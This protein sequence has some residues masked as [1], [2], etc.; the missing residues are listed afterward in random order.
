MIDSMAYTKKIEIQYYTETQD[1]I[2]N[3]EQTWTTLYTPWAKIEE[4]A[5]GKEYYE[6]AQTNSENDV[7]FKLRYSSVLEGKLTSELRV[8]Y[9]NAYYDVKHM[10]GIEEHSLEV[11]IRTVKINGGVR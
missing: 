1:T 4:N 6:A 5:T 7:V 2:G 9:K 11:A 8:K 10:D 3:D